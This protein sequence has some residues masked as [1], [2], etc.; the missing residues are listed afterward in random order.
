M[1]GIKRGLTA[2]IIGFFLL[3][4]TPSYASKNVRIKEFLT[5][6][7][8]SQDYYLKATIDA[9]TVIAAQIRKDMSLCIADW[10]SDDPG[11]I[12]QRNTEILTI[13]EEYPDSYPIAIIIAVLQKQCGRFGNQG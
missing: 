5:Y 6:D 7:Y 8:N 12:K 4:C 10:Y 13:M 3:N 1:F 9:A 2:S 11:T